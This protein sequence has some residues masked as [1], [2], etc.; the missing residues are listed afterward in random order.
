VN[1]GSGEVGIDAIAL[2]EKGEEFLEG[3]RPVEGLRGDVKTPAGDFGI[4]LD[5]AEERPIAPSPHR[6]IAPSAHRAVVQGVQTSAE[7]AARAVHRLAQGPE[8]VGQVSGVAAVEG[9]YVVPGRQVLAAVDVV[10]ER[11]AK[12]ELPSLVAASR[13]A[14][15]LRRAS[16]GPQFWSWQ[17]PGGSPWIPSRR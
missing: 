11:R 10:V 1:L 4:V 14:V 8:E 16:L 12:P 9:W 2:G 6:P 7:V 17:V 15:G 3:R 13:P 5:Q